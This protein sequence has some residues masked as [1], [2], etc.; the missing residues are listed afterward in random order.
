M[1]RPAPDRAST[2]LASGLAS[3]LASTDVRRFGATRPGSRAAGRRRFYDADERSDLVLAFARCSVRQRPS[4]GSDVGRGRATR[5]ALS[6]CAPAIMPRWGELQLQAED[7]G[8]QTDRGRSPAD[9]T[10]VDMDRVASAMRAIEDA[11]RRPARADRRDGRRSARSRRR[12]RR[13]HGCSRSRRRRARWRW[14]CCSAS[15]I[16]G[17]GA[18]F[19]QRG[20]R[21]RSAPRPGAATAPTSSCNRSARRCSPASSARWRFATT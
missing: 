18:H 16:C 10:G 20:R 8:G 4:H 5:P 9:P 21:R 3:G 14:R 7:G 13:R 15:S 1:W 2:A 19:R 6:G 17:G 12:R 11:P